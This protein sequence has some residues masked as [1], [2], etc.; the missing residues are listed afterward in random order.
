MGGRV[1]WVGEGEGGSHVIGVGRGSAPSGV[2]ERRSTCSFGLAE[3]TE[4]RSPINMLAPVA[5]RGGT[6]TPVADLPSRRME[7]SMASLRDG[8]VACA[9]LLL[10]PYYGVHIFST[11]LRRSDS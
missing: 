10:K 7:A 1:G 3:G 8:R 9:I 5:A 11:R 2:Q 4:H 6:W